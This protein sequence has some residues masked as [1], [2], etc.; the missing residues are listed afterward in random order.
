MRIPYCFTC[1]GLFILFT[2]AG[3]MTLAHAETPP[4]ALSVI[5]E[6]YAND[7]GVPLAL[8]HAVISVESGWQRNAKN[9]SSVGLMQITPSTARS[10]GY[11]GT[12]M[13]LYDPETNINF[14]VK[15]LALAYEQAGGDLCGTVSRYQSGINVQKINA[16][17]RAYCQRAKRF[18]S[19]YESA[20]DSARPQKEAAN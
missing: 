11:K 14:G 9:G 20:A 16:A 7:H 1:V 2:F 13:G 12:M 4:P 8:V 10:L 5:A 15:Y 19:A 3:V 6:K 17:N 18:I